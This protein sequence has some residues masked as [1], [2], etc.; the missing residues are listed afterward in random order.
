MKHTQQNACFRNVPCSTPK[1]ARHMHSQCSLFYS[2]FSKHTK[3]ASP[4]TSD[5]KNTPP[6]RS[7]GMEL[8]PA[9]QRNISPIIDNPNASSSNI[10]MEGNLL[11]NQVTEGPGLTHKNLDTGAFSLSNAVET[12]SQY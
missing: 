8:F 7:I 5:I 11:P 6:I 1:H 10:N 12:S 9:P 4:I 2:K 3:F